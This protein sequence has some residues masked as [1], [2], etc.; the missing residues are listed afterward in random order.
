MEHDYWL[1]RERASFML[2]GKATSAEAKLIHYELAGLYSVKAARSARE[3][4]TAGNKF[5]APVADVVAPEL[6]GSAK[7]DE[8]YYRE[9]AQGAEYLASVAVG[10]VEMAEHRRMATI[11]LHRAREAA[12]GE[13]LAP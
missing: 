8:R 4:V 2:A 7:A 3:A 6:R 5:T 10:A 13:H 11:Y 9:L 1:G 12:W